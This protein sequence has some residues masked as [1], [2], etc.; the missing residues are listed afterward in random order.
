LLAARQVL[1]VVAIVQTIQVGRP[2]L[3]QHKVIMV[4]VQMAERM[5]RGVVEVAL[6]ALVQPQVVGLLIPARMLGLV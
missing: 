1:V 6:V 2:A 4:V 5:L 3:H